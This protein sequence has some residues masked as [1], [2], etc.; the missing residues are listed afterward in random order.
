MIVCVDETDPLIDEYR[1]LPVG[2][3]IRPGESAGAAAKVEYVVENC[4]A[5][6]YVLMSDRC[7]PLSAGWYEAMTSAAL[8]RRVALCKATFDGAPR[9]GDFSA[10]AA[11]S[12]AAIYAV[13][14]ISPPGI[15][16]Y[17]LD[18]FWNAAPREAGIAVQVDVRIDIPDYSYADAVRKRT[19]AKRREYEAQWK[20]FRKSPAYAEA[21]ERLRCVS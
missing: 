16:H 8:P 13:G 21:V 7:V 9:D 4:T 12:R 1:A 3:V 2:L 14:W 17:G 6:V 19:L 18:N 11:I 15:D 20:R 5:D 10:V